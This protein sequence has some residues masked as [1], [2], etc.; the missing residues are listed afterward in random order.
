MKQIFFALLAT[1]FVACQSAPDAD[2][3]QTGDK[4]EVKTDAKAAAMPL[5]L[6][7][8]KVHFT[9]TKPTGMH[10]G[11][12]MLKEGSLSAAEGKLSGGSFVIDI[13]SMVITDKDTSGAAS[14]KGH[15]L[16]P[17][18]FDGGKF[19][20]AKFEITGVAP[21]VADSTNKSVVAG[22][23]FTITGNLTLKDSTKSVSFPAKVDMS[24]AGVVAMADFNID[25]SQWGLAYGNDKS[26]GDK[27]IRPEVNIKLNISAKK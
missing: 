26:L 12:F 14:L 2:K 4:Q 16:S 7:T 19:G 27:F 21:F 15:L 3:A 24:D 13:N 25:R 5:D 1:G 22:A 11:D 17:D 8:S 20:T 23:N 6:A 18:F 10:E 9:G